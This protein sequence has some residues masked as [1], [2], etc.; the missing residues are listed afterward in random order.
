[1]SGVF[2]IVRTR[3]MTPTF[4]LG[5]RAYHIG[6]HFHRGCVCHGRILGALKERDFYFPLASG[7]T[8]ASESA[9]NRLGTL[10]NTLEMS[11]NTF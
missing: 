9:S 5:M 7:P 6:A 2:F 10:A 4:W 8:D 11:C 3:N 1:M